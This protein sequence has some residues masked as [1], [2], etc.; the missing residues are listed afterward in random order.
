MKKLL[1]ILSWLL[2]L[3]IAIVYIYENPSKIEM[4]TIT[5]KIEED[6][7]KTKKIIKKIINKNIKI[8]IKC[9]NLKI[10]GLPE[11]IPCNFPNART[12]PEKVIAP[13]NVPI[14]I[15]IRLLF[16]IVPALP[17]LKDSGL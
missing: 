3:I 9:W 11:T 12:D 4:T 2:S 8:L 7:F 1:F 15:S 6:W 17:M 13:I 16:K 10:I 14:L 5:Q